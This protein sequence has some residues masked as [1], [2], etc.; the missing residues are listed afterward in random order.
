MK[1]ARRMFVKA[2]M[3]AVAMKSVAKHA[4]DPQKSVAA[5]RRMSLQEIPAQNLLG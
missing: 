4:Q 5:L 3:P 2:E 1:K